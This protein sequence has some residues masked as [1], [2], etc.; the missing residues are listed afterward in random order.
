ML[1]ALNA[2][3]YRSSHPPILKTPHEDSFNAVNLGCDVSGRDARD[4]GN[5]RGIESFQKEQ[6]YLPSMGF[7]S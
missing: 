6:Q 1:Q 2:G 5:G 4:I 3:G 7:S